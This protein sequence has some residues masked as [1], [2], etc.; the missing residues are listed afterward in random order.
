MLAN[1][2]KRVMKRRESVGLAS[3]TETQE[4]LEYELR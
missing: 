1:L 2:T 4:V 3:S